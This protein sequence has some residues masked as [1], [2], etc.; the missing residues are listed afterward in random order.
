MREDFF[1]DSGLVKSGVLV[2]VGKFCPWVTFYGEYRLDSANRGVWGFEDPDPPL[3]EITGEIG[4]FFNSWK[5]EVS[6]KFHLSFFWVFILDGRD[7]SK[8]GIFLSSSQ[9][10]AEHSI[11]KVLSLLS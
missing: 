10:K 6:R 7:G 1:G 3:G 11:I 8:R 2:K 5:R 9:F 4:V